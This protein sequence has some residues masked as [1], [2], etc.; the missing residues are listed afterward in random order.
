MIRTVC[1][2]P[3]PLNRRAVLRA[4]AI[5]AVG[6]L[7][8][9]ATA[10]CESRFTD[11]RIALGTG[12]SQGVYYAL[13]GALADAWQHS[14][15]LAQRPT[16]QATA[17]SVDNLRLLGD[18]AV[19]VIFSAADVADARLPL[20]SRPGREIRALARIYDDALQVVTPANSP[21]TQVTDLRGKRVSIGA[22]DSGVIVMAD[23]LLTAAGLSST[24]DLFASRLGIDDSIAAL[25]AGRIDAFF[26]SGGLPT[27]GVNSLA[28][29][30]PIRLLDLAPQMPA[31]RKRYPVYDVGTVPAATYGIPQAVTTMFIRNFLLVPALM[32]DQLAN[33]LV[34]GLFAATDELV[35]T[36]PAGRAI[37]ARSA[38]G[39]QPVP[40]HPGALRY[41]RE[42]KAYD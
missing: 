14:L 9:A 10:G 26:W 23:R 19:D 2:R 39:T 30:T 20:P 42:N 24:T 21:I 41:Y 1:P 36:N 31:L 13:G 5:T 35:Q 11:T 25:R 33:A 15:G 22:T 28:A 6:G 17:G 34:A 18:G 3:A 16:V 8:G 7:G 32:P 37:D 29:S 27:G 12:G 4:G 38:I 40:L